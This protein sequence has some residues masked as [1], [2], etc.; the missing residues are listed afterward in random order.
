MCD[1]WAHDGDEL[2]NRQ[3]GSVNWRRLAESENRLCLTSGQSIF[4]RKHDYVMRWNN[5]LRGHPHTTYRTHACIEEAIDWLLWAPLFHVFWLCQHSCNF[6]WNHSMLCLNELR[7][8]WNQRNFVTH[9]RNV[10]HN[11]IGWA[12]ANYIQ[13]PYFCCM[14]LLFDRRKR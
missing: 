3:N 14:H 13:L 1:W 12:D 7:A 10:V 6:I 2:C 8:K 5:P 9:F 4:D 11:I